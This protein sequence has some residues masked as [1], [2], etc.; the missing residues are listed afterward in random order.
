MVDFLVFRVIAECVLQHID[1]AQALERV[2]RIRISKTLLKTTNLQKFQRE[3]HG[4]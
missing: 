3:A 1:K 4:F 2:T